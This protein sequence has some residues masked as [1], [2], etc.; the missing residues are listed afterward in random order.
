MFLSKKLIEKAFQ[1][2]RIAAQKIVWL[3]V[4]M[5]DLKILAY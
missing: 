2:I 4:A 5:H 3:R 1:V